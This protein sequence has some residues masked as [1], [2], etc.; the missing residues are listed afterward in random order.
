MRH[1][2]TIQTI[3]EIKS[4]EGADAIEAARINGWW[5]VVKKDEFKVEDKVCYFEIDSWIPTHLAP[6]LSKGKEPRT[7]NDV[8]GERLRTVK[9]RGQL[10]QGLVLPYTGSGNEGDDLTEALGIQKW[11]RPVSAQLAGIARG[12]FPSFICKT[13]QE[14][15]QNLPEVFEDLHAKYEVSIKLDGSSMTV[16][17]H[18][19]EMGVCSR[20]IDLKLDQTGNTF[21]D[22]AKELFTDR[23]FDGLA[24]QGELMGACIQCNREKL[25]KH[26]FFVFDIWSIEGRCYWDTQSVRDFCKRNNLQHVPVL[27]KEVSLTDLKLFTTDAILKY[28]D[29]V[30][31][32]HPVREG[33]VFK[34]IDGQSSFKAISNLFLL[35]EA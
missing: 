28:A 15:I 11:E 27:H 16:Y 21:V 7:Y 31:L 23:Y 9:L 6:F 8:Q 19:G 2:A 26:T 35:K 32:T 18:E 14:R 1:L 13:D 33:L 25:D 24:I 10:S 4:I 22:V 3:A 17:F 29:G 5:V 30:S 20:N 34:N 12:N